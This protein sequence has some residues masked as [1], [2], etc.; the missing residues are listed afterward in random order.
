MNKRLLSIYFSF[1]RA[2]FPMRNFTY[3]W[4]HYG[5]TAF[6]YSLGLHHTLNAPAFTSLRIA[7]F[8]NRDHTESRLYYL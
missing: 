5:L 3:W 4:W 8:A 6:N 1:P 7:S 2:L